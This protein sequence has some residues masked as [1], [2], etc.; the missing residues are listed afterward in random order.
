M[1]FSRRGFTFLEVIVVISM[2]GLFA[3]LAAPSF[4][5]MMRDLNVSR[6]AMQIAEIHRAALL[7]SNERAEMISFRSDSGVSFTI[8]QPRLDSPGNALWGARTCQSI[9][10]SDASRVIERNLTL[11][12]GDAFALS[13]VRLVDQNGSPKARA[14]ICFSRQAVFVRYDE[15]EFEPLSQPIRFEV[16]NQQSHITRKVAITPSG[17]PRVWR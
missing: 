4:T 16:E 1:L 15:A 12:Q 7:L 5:R 17:I 6:A 10:W 2:I 11:R 9:A 8:K 14:D 3:A 13:S